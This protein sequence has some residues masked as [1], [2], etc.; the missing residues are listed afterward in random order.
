MVAVNVKRLGWWEGLGCC[1][2]FSLFFTLFLRR[3]EG[4]W[5][6]TYLD[7]LEGL[8]AIQCQLVGPG[9]GGCNM[10]SGRNVK[11]LCL[12][13]VQ[14]GCF[15]VCRSEQ[16]CTSLID[17]HDIVICSFCLVRLLAF[18]SSCS[19]GP[20]RKDKSFQRP[21]E[22]HCSHRQKASG[23]ERLSVTRHLPV[24]YLRLLASVLIRKEVSTSS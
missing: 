19:R 20:C 3:T 7:K 23:Q 8:R 10:G 16:R 15:L 4:D 18:E 24:T 17:S 21:R 12:W 1:M 9:G 6:V 13:I 5:G 11:W 22:T 14:W 2:K